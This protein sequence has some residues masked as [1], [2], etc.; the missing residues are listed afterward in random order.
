[1]NESAEIATEADGLC[2]AVIDF[3]IHALHYQKKS[4]LG[5]LR[6]VKMPSALT[7]VCSQSALCYPS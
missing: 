3:L 2:A 1:M 6:S 4:S 7:C 5:M